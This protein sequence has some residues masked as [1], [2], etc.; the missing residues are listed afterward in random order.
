VC[1]LEPDE[2]PRQI[3]GF[4]AHAPGL[5]R[6]PVRPAELGPDAAELAHLVTP[7]GDVQTLPCHFA[8]RGGLDGFYVARLVRRG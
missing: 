1:S 5:A 4:L 8:E 3:E 7:A 2:G 6:M